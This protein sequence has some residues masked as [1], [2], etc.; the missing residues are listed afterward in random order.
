MAIYLCRWPNGDCSVV[1]AKT[2]IDAIELLDEWG[3]AEEA[4]LTRLA[5][6]MF[7]FKLRDDGHLELADIGEATHE[8]IMEA[9]YPELDNAFATAEWDETGMDYSFKG[10][11]RIRAAVE[12]ERTRLRDCQPHAKGAETELGREIQNQT[13]AP[14]VLVNRIVRDAARKRLVPYE[15]KGKRPN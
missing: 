3:N 1:N 7:D 14:S 2:K 6:C 8:C 4:S 11:E 15:G 13:G 5:D 10:R 12:S 9:C